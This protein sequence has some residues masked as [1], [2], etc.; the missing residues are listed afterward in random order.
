M[1]TTE[2]LYGCQPNEFANL[3][4]REAL[5]R[6]IEFARRHMKTI[7]NETNRLFVEGAKRDDLQKKY[8]QQ[9]AIYEAIQFN[10]RLLDEIRET[11][12]FR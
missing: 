7:I 9:K 5:S 12:E 11:K 2:Y 8:H 3:P 1:K 6:K 10:E 4:Y